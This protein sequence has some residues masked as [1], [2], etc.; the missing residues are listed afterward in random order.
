MLVL[1]SLHLQ[2]IEAAKSKLEERR[3]DLVA[4]LE[5]RKGDLEYPE[6]QKPELDEEIAPGLQSQVESAENQQYQSK[7]ESW[8]RK[9]KPNIERD[10]QTLS[11]IIAQLEGFEQSIGDSKE[12]IKQALD[13]NVNRE[14]IEQEYQRLMNICATNMAYG[15]S[16]ETTRVGTDNSLFSHSGSSNFSGYTPNPQ[17]ISKFLDLIRDPELVSELNDYDVSRRI[18]NKIKRNIAEEQKKLEDEQKLAQLIT[19]PEI[20]QEVE[21]YIHRLSSLLERQNT[22]SEEQRN[23]RLPEE[24]SKLV[25]FFNRILGKTKKQNS[26]IEEVA[27]ELRG[28]KEEIRQLYQQEKDNPNY[29]LVY[30]AYMEAIGRYTR[31][32]SPYIIDRTPMKTELNRI[33]NLEQMSQKRDLREFVNEYINPQGIID[34][35]S[36][37]IERLNAELSENQQVTETKY[38]ALSDKGKDL[39]AQ[40]IYMGDIKARYIDVSERDRY[41]VSPFVS[42]L[43][44]ETLM[45]AQNIKTPEDAKKYGIDISQGEI[46]QYQEFANK[47][48]ASIETI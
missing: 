2:L 32:T 12:F 36:Q 3:N 13:V 40:G 30:N 19:N 11:Q 6:Y 9:Q 16:M 17:E 35:L 18:D 28:V 29:A 8:E 37:T 31:E 21:T 20:C 7:R 42:S 38:A 22:L 44:L 14:G 34:G 15:L 43:I 10:I 27:A 47:M 39:V 5:K 41:G 4:L 45:D 26:R 24:T 25:T 23:L 1:F 46:E 33:R 48:V